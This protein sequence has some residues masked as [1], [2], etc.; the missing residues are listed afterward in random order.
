MKNCFVLLLAWAVC[1][2]AARS[3]HRTAV[4][5]SARGRRSYYHEPFDVRAV[6]SEP[7]CD[8]ALIHQPSSYSST[9]L[10]LAH[11]FQDPPNAVA[12]YLPSQYAWME[13]KPLALPQRFHDPPPVVAVYLPSQYPAF[14]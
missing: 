6:H 9:Q 8:H 5:I 7:H 11:R 14:A 10:A 3:A 13:S 2:V 4:H 12:V 1:V